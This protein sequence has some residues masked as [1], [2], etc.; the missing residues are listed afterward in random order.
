MNKH[1][2]GF[3][4]EKT[5]EAF[6]GEGGLPDFVAR[7]VVKERIEAHISD[8]TKKQRLD[9]DYPYGSYFQEGEISESEKG[10]YKSKHKGGTLIELLKTKKSGSDS[11]DR[12]GDDDYLKIYVTIHTRDNAIDSGQRFF[13]NH[14]FITG[15]KLYIRDPND[16]G[17]EQ[18]LGT[19]TKFSKKFVPYTDLGE[20][21]NIRRNF[22]QKKDGKPDF[23]FSL[24]TGYG[25]PEPTK[26]V[27]AERT[28]Q[29]KAGGPGIYALEIQY[30]N[31]GQPL[32]NT[33]KLARGVPKG[34]YLGLNSG[35]VLPT[36]VYTKNSDREEYLTELRTYPKKKSTRASSVKVKGRVVKKKKSTKRRKKKSNRK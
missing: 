2:G 9:A 36:T 23:Q 18:L 16:K 17:R 35:T 10:Y 8:L 12:K 27:T 24:R 21:I 15:D 32:V 3:D 26:E 20:D 29:T 13:D 34:D 11:P 1:K 28:K 6:E 31:D 4:P 25:Y 33:Y 14:P 5:R 30:E 7:Q 22:Y 19:I